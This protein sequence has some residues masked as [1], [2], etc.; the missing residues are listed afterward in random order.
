[1][2]RTR[3]KVSDPG[4]YDT[5]FCGPMCAELA[6]NGPPPG[7]S[8]SS[9]SSS[10]QC[11]LLGCKNKVYDGGEFCSEGHANF[12]DD[13]SSGWTGF[14]RAVTSGQATGCA[15]CLVMPRSEGSNYCSDDCDRKGALRRQ[16]P[17]PPAKPAPP[18]PP[19][20]SSSSFSETT[21]AVRSRFEKRWDDPRSSSTPKIYRVQ[22]IA[23]SNLYKARW[24]SCLNKLSA[25]GGHSIKSTFWGG[26]CGCQLASDEQRVG[27]CKSVYCRVCQVIRLAFDKPPDADIDLADGLYGQGIYTRTNPAD[28]HAHARA[29]NGRGVRVVIAC[30]VAIPMGIPGPGPTS[31]I[32]ETGRVFCPSPDFIIPRFVIVYSAKTV[33]DSNGSSARMPGAMPSVQAS[34]QFLPHSTSRASTP[35]RASA[36][37]RLDPDSDVDEPTT[38][39]TVTRSLPLPAPIP[40]PENNADAKDRTI[41]QLR[42]E[43]RRKDAELKDEKAKRR[44]AEAQ[45]REAEAQL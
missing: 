17:P 16:P 8:S 27:P 20:S 28:A 32:D 38:S 14:R 45:K 26:Y 24:E 7:T 44:E 5:D 41:A 37:R 34:L 19:S 18:A 33:N 35:R 42:A 13:D 40:A 9:S 29:N 11:T 23:L 3:Y 39:P 43:L 36:N 2:C 25:V 1:Y 15:T 21:E 31:H 30:S 4:D 12:F 10:K 6:L 22:E